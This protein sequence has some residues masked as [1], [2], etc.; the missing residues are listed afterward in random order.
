MTFF[1]KIPQCPCNKYLD[2]EN[3]KHDGL[4]AE[5]KKTVLDRIPLERADVLEGKLDL[6]ICSGGV[7]CRN[8]FMSTICVEYFLSIKNFDLILFYF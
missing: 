1:R 3:I 4:A 5:Q 6:V 2:W 8:F 7:N